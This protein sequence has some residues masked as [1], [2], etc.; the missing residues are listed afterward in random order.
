MQ[1]SCISFSLP[2]TTPS[3]TIHSLPL[4]RFPP[5]ISFVIFATPTQSHPSIST[6]GLISVLISA[7]STPSPPP[8]PLYTLIRSILVSLHHYP[9]TYTSHSLPYPPHHHDNLYPFLHLPP[10]LAL[11]PFSP[12]PPLPFHLGTPLTPCFTLPSPPT[13]YH[14]YPRSPP[15]STPCTAP[16]LP[17]STTTPSPRYS[18][19]TPC[20]ALPSPPTLYHLYPRSPPAS[21]ATPCPASLVPFARPCSAY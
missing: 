1:D 5:P 6:I 13:L 8:P 2:S 20:F 12:P 16:L 4:L 17:S 9:F 18:P 11:L 19:L 3:N 10:P 7:P 21:S 14:L 15:P